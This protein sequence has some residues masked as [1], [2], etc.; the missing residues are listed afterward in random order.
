[1]P[2]SCLGYKYLSFPDGEFPQ[3]Y[4]PTIFD[5]FATKTIYQNQQY[6][7]S[8]VSLNSICITLFQWDTAGVEAFDKLRPLSYIGADIFLLCFDLVNSSSLENSLQR[9]FEE[10]SKHAP[11]VPILL[12]GTKSM[13]HNII[14]PL[15]DLRVNK[16]FL[17]SAK[18]KNP[19]LQAISFDM[20][21]EMAKKIGATGYTET[22]A[23]TGQA[24]DQVFNEVMRF[25]CQFCC[26]QTDK[27]RKQS[28]G[29]M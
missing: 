18:K 23:L 16:E 29:V 3:D 13:L 24:V 4:I 22:S 7:V 17:T 14:L 26:A 21:V 20:G 15:V 10:L 19:K 25:G 5:N 6:S 28:C 1:M 11:H 9:W 27:N 2:V 12:C 8:L